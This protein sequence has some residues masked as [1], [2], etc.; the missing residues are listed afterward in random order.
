MGKELIN[1][2][3]TTMQ[4]YEVMFTFLEGYYQRLN[5]PELL[6]MLLGGFRLRDDGLPVDPAA[7]EDWLEAVESVLKEEDEK[8]GA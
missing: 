5:Q 4:Y 6:G 2:S 7:W 8:K 1:D 3:L